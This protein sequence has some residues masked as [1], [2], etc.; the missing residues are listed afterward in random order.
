[1]NEIQ[2]K[3]IM[4][5]DDSALTDSVTAEAARIEEMCYAFSK[6]LYEIG[7]EHAR[8]EEALREKIRK[9]EQDSKWQV[10]LKKSVKEKIKKTAKRIFAWGRRITGVL[11]IKDLL[12]RTVLFKKMSRKGIIKKLGE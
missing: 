3:L 2:E 1:M 12:K 5:Q 7:K 9:L 11:G 6:T 8:E 4:R 10:L